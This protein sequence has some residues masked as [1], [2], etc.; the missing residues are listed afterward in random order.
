[1]YFDSMQKLPSRQKDEENLSLPLSRDNYKVKFQKLLKL[2]EK[3][4][5]EELQKKYEV[6][7]LI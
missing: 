7:K 5:E 2:E 1:M 3:A 4:H 6:Y